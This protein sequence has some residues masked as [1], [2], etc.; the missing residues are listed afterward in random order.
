MYIC[1]WTAYKNNGARI[2]DRNKHNIQGNDIFQDP[3]P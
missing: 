3:F 2:P 1:F